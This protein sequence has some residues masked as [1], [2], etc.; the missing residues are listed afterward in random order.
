[1]SQPGNE[2]F[3][4]GP[5]Q[6]AEPLTP[7]Q[8]AQQLGEWVA[9]KNL[10]PYDA[11]WEPWTD[12]EDGRNALTLWTAD[13]D[14]GGRIP[15]AEIRMEGDEIFAIWGT[16]EDRDAMYTFVE[17]NQDPIMDDDV[18]ALL[19]GKLLEMPET[20]NRDEHLQTIADLRLAKALDTKLMI[21][22]EAQLTRAELTVVYELER[23][24]EELGMYDL[25]TR[26]REQRGNRDHSALAKILGETIGEEAK[27]S[28]DTLNKLAESF[29][30]E[31]LTQ[32]AFDEAL[33]ATQQRWAENGVY[34]YLLNRVTVRGLKHNLRD[35]HFIVTATPNV[36]ADAQQL[37]QFLQHDEDM[38]LQLEQPGILHEAYYRTRVPSP[39]LSGYPLGDG[40][41][42]FSIIP[43][44]LEQDFYG[45]PDE[46][47]T[48]E[49][50]RQG[51]NPGLNL[52]APTM[53]EMS[54][55]WSILKQRY[56]YRFESGEWYDIEPGAFH[57][58][59]APFLDGKA[60]SSSIDNG[61][62]TLRSH[63]EQWYSAR[64]AIS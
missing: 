3:P 47:A 7:Q 50:I 12:P 51:E 8:L 13:P 18:L 42:K 53:L 26:I 22:P 25:L 11:L 60:P 46:L 34:E 33:A 55:Y 15:R 59:L 14:T 37:Y 38:H 19:A 56:P 35:R 49:V 17:G 39:T 45:T 63:D 43:T 27:R 1:M 20:A 36:S 32:E 40:P 62:L 28:F 64:L 58:D 30:T 21:K 24:C 61:A 5:E 10:Q 9:D 29:G 2:S 54:A 41:I 48:Q 23:D 31:P 6:G 57:F 44:K 16:P 52:H 4:F